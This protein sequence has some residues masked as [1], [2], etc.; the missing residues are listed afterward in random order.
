VPVPRHTGG[1]ER[2]IRAAERF[3]II[4]ALVRGFA[5]DFGSAPRRGFGQ[6]LAI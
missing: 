4:S 3:G 6:L 1:D 5:T 2:H